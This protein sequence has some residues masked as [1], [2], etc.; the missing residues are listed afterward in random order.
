MSFAATKTESYKEDNET[1]GKSRLE[2]F[3][4][5]KL[6]EEIRKL[7]PDAL[8]PGSGGPVV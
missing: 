2:R 3:L 5:A 1:A 8:Y 4:G 6:W 7:P